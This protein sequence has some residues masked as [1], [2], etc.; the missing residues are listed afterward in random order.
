MN[1]RETV[2]RH[3]RTAP[4]EA[5]TYAAPIIE[6]LEEREAQ[7]ANSIMVEAERETELSATQVAAMLT[8]MGMSLPGGDTVAG[9]TDPQMDPVGAGIANLKM[10]VTVL[11]RLA[12]QHGLM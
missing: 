2:E 11:E 4:R 5:M 8:Q 10:R 9:G 3:L 7:I 12:R 6:A 1:I